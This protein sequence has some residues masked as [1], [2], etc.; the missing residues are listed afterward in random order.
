[1]VQVKRKNDTE[2]NVGRV[3]EITSKS[4]HGDGL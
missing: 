4:N 3:C 1:M 2:Y